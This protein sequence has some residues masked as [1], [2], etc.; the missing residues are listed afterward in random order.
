[1]DDYRRIETHRSCHIPCKSDNGHRP[2]LPK[3]SRAT[4]AAAA[5]AAEDHDDSSNKRRMTDD[6]DES[7]CRRNCLGTRNRSERHQSTVRLQ[8]STETNELEQ[9][10]EITA[11]A[12]N[13]EECPC[14]RITLELED[15]STC[16]IEDQRRSCGAGTRY[17]RR[18]CIVTSTGQL[19][20]LRSVAENK[21]KHPTTSL[22]SSPLL[23]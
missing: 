11:T 4:A 20:P 3:I 18:K 12:A 16:L 8:Q 5:A 1:M 7:Q 2:P 22:L 23:L 9:T 13:T 21:F 19:A 10:H 6:V 14:E 15:W 17:R